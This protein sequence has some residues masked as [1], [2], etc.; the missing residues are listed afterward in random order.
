[1]MEGS[2]KGKLKHEVIGI[3]LIA[4]GIFLFLSLVSYDP[5]DPSFFFLYLFQD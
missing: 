1:M 5:M 3:L 4:A 2:F